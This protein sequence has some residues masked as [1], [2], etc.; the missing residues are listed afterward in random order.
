MRF[1]TRPGKAYKLLEPQ[2]DA[3]VEKLRKCL[4]DAKQKAEKGFALRRLAGGE[5]T[6]MRDI[7]TFTL[8]E[9]NGDGGGGC[10][11]LRDAG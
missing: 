6:D 10:R 7:E 3:E 4:D 9:F 1:R 8:G 5:Q 11:L 2:T